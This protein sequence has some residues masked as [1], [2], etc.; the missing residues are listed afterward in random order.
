[1]VFS[2]IVAKDPVSRVYGEVFTGLGNQTLQSILGS[3]M[4]FNLKDAAERRMG[5][6]SSFSQELV[7]NR[8]RFSRV[9]DG[10]SEDLER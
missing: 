2:L 3:H 5:I 8:M 1:M 7:V 4:F 6:D 10:D 9:R